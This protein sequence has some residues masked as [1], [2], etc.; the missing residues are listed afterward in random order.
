M[1]DFVRYTDSGLS[2]RARGTRAERPCCTHLERPIPACAGNPWA[3]HAKRPNRKAYPRVRGEPLRSDATK[4]PGAGLSP[5]ARGTPMTTSLPIKRSWPIPAC[6]GNPLYLHL[7]A[8]RIGAYP[9]VRG[10]PGVFGQRLR[11]RSRLS[12]RARGTRATADM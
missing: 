9:R 12:P 11:L 8:G 2:P 1:Q 4:S 10:E 3:R 6:A 5:R 7:V